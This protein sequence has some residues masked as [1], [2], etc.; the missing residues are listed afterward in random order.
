MDQFEWFQPLIFFLLNRNPLILSGFPSFSKKIVFLHKSFFLN[1][2]FRPSVA[3]NTFNTFI[4]FRFHIKSGDFLILFLSLALR[5][6]VW[7]HTPSA[8]AT[9][10][11]VV[12]VGEGL[13]TADPNQHAKRILWSKVVRAV[14]AGEF[15]SKP[16]QSILLKVVKNKQN[17]GRL[18][19][20]Q[21]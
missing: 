18:Y 2:Q 15:G 7:C 3:L 4:Y 19:W 17:S 8:K 10:C 6:L 13:G 1:T 12:V 16:L 5:L 11:V 14:T 20:F 21:N 9:D